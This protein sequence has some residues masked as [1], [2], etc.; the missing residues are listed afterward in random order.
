MFFR[1][2]L[3][4]NPSAWGDLLTNYDGTT[5]TYDSIGNPTKWRNS[6]SLTWDGRTLTSQTLTNGNSITYKYNSDGIRTQKRVFDDVASAYITHNY[7]LDGTKILSETVTDNAYYNSYTLYYVY[8]ANGSIT[9]LHYNGAPYYF[10][11]NIQGDVLRICNAGGAVVVEYAYDAWGNILSVT[12]SMAST[13]GQYNPFRYRGYYYDS[14]TDLYYLNSRYYDAE[15]GRFISAD[16]AIVLTATPIE[17]TDKNL[18][19]YCDNNPIMRKD[20]NGAFWHII[21]G[22]VVGVATQYVSDVVTNLIDGKSFGESLK[23]TS[24]WADY[25]CAALSGAL[26]A[27]GVGI[28][29]AIAANAALSG[30]TYL[31]NCAITGEDVNAFDFGVSVGVGVISGIVGGRGVDGAKL[32]GIS[33]TSKQILKTAVSPKK[34]AMYTS[35]LVNVKKEVIIGT[36]RTVAAGLTSNAVNYT[37]DLITADAS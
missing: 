25:G 36:V 26:A 15:V 14:E 30:A 8:D 17:M 4:D 13:L 7:V 28:G 12:G 34:I 11:K 19:A 9:G 6:S 32:R 35:K 1:Q 2:R 10:Q 37:Y 18:F 24:T 23:P 20:D 3:G 5:I 31:A 27:S 21:V 16:K 22:A 29:V 33:N